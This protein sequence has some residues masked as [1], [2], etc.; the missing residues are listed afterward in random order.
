[1][2]LADLPFP[3][4]ELLKGVDAYIITHFHPDHID[5]GPGEIFGASLDKRTPV[6][7]QDAEDAKILWDQGFADL[8]VL[9]QNS[10]YKNTELIKTPCR[11]GTNVPCGPACGAVF[12]APGEKT[13]Y[14]AGDTIWYDSVKETIREYKPEVIIL[15]A[16][17]A[18]LRFFGR[19]IMDQ[20]DVLKVHEEAP[21]AQLVISH[22]GSVAH[23]AVTRAE[24]RDFA[25]KHGFLDKTAIPSDGGTL[26]Y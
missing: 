5:Y 4:E 9:Y 17:G 15:Y 25:E 13:L 11:H 23:A 8:T 26:A 3:K 21:S 6:F 2:P 7:V 20:H 22:M 19:L 14:L 18:S 10:K 12:R 24:M 16:C 1:M